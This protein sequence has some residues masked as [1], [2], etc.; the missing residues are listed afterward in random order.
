MH[1]NEYL[2]S[3]ELNNFYRCPDGTVGRTCD[4]LPDVCTVVDPC[5]EG[6]G[7]CDV[8][9]MTSVCTCTDESKIYM[10]NSLPKNKILDLS[11]F[12]GFAG[13]KINVDEIL[14]FILGRVENI[15]GKG[16]NAGYKHFLLFP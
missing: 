5:K 12:K 13:G 7:D 14:K 6:L 1:Q 3:K 9:N 11:K 8:A 4:A 10:F 2:W 16:E 15:V